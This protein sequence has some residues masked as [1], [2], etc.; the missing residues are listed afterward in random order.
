MR[1]LRTVVAVLACCLGLGALSF[2]SHAA[3]TKSAQKEDQTPDPQQAIAS[4]NIADGLKIRLFAA[5]PMISNP[6]CLAID[7][8]GRVYVGETDRQQKGVEDNRTSPFWLQDDLASQTLADR[9][10]M[11]QKWQHKFKG[12]MA[13]FSQG[14]DRIV[15]LQDSDYDGV[16][17]KQIIYADNFR[18]PL[19][20]T[21]AGLLALEGDIYYTCIPSLVKLRD[22]N[23]D[24]KADQRTVMHKGFGVRVCLRGHDLHGLTLGPDGKLYFSLGDRGYDL[25]TPEGRK[26]HDPATGGVFRC[27]P[28]G[29]ELELYAHG[30]RNP[31]DLAFDHE[32]NLFTV[33][34]NSD[35]GDRARLV[36]ILEGGQTGW[37]MCYQTM[38]GNYRRGQWHAEKIWHLQNPDQPAWILPPVA[39]ITSGPSGLARYP[40]VGLPAKYNDRFLIVD[41]RGGA[42]GSSI[43]S[44]SVKPKGATF[45]LNEHEPFLQ[46]MAATDLEFGYDGKLYIT[47]WIGGWTGQQK[48]RVY[49]VEDA[50]GLA[51]AAE[52]KT[53]ELFARGFK[54]RDAKE[55]EAL[56]KHPDYRVRL[57]AHLALADK[58]AAVIPA[59]SKLAAEAGNE[60]PAR[61]HAAWALGILSRKQQAAAAEAL[62]KL[63]QDSDRRLRAIAATALGDAK[64]KEARQALIKLVDDADP[65]VAAL[66]AIAVG[67]LQVKEAVPVLANRLR[68]N[69]DADVFL[70]HACVMGL[71]GLG[72]ADAILPL[73]KDAS[74]SVRLGALLALRRLGDARLAALLKDPDVGIVTEAAR[75]VHD[76]PLD[77]QKELAAVA[78]AL[79]AKSPDALVRRVINA[80][81]RVRTTEAAQSLV[82]LASNA[83]LSDAMRVE[84]IEALAS[85]AQPSPRD[86][87]IGDWRP[88]AAVDQAPA[89]A[90][91]K[92][93]MFRLLD[94]S[95][96]VQSA[97]INAGQKLGVRVE[98]EQ[99]R[100]ILTSTTADTATRVMAMRVLLGYKEESKQQVL[101]LALRSDSPALR[102]EARRQLALIDP[103]RGLPELIHV[104]SDP[105]AT[106]V[107]RQA[108]FGAL[109]AI[110]SDEAAAAV[111]EPLR[112]LVA[113]TLEPAIQLD[114]LYAS[115]GFK[116]AKKPGPEVSKLLQVLSEYEKKVMGSKDP[117]TRFRVALEGGNAV[118][119][120]R[121]FYEKAETE[122]LRCH[123]IEGGGSGEAGPDLTG[124]GAR[125]P[126]SYVLESIL[127]PNREF[128]QGFESVI[129]ELKDGSRLAGIV[130]S[131]QP[132]KL[133]LEVAV[134]GEDEYSDK[135]SHGSGP[136]VKQVTVER[137]SIKS[138][139]RGLSGMPEGFGKALTL[140]ELR[141]LVEFVHTNQP[142]STQ[143]P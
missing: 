98:A 126:R 63:T 15:A 40:G 133:V 97:A 17:D 121:I 26:L 13:Y 93:R 43:Q 88:L 6:V 60:S 25:T 1:P 81:L 130:R 77:A 84:A 73:T 20:G 45:E 104:A 48:G 119:G 125:K 18:D 96:P 32:G 7:E 85:W 30:L 86:R 64:V 131:E 68:T 110:K 74:R 102:G 92:D 103:K 5:E 36:Y 38:E 75:A 128:A 8:Q 123:K 54:Q 138:R 87:V 107:E 33:D 69:A 55:L 24:F 143:A 111:I 116:S 132:A 134:Q 9:L 117:T 56:L 106:L 118:L 58:G 105:Q 95:S 91:I 23:G 28:D 80:Q 53:A 29:S 21:G 57:R 142:V 82:K 135:A 99:L 140:A 12:G 114:V 49:T 113:G 31:Q 108:A 14:E 70:R 79:P 22:T 46:H 136:Q 39:H 59:L 89:A 139:Q 76:L 124:I 34:N 94:S 129:L 19:D 3:E 42:S 101:D 72:E 16:A 51:A 141:D 78:D 65:H 109:G 11:Y 41:F 2:S 100:Q 35:A 115:Q 47:D 67:K 50:H 137:S 66:A 61:L 10:A 71:A 127:E 90:A 4:F 44:F 37:N 122:C 120:R 52:A 62:L 112:R 27:N 83:G